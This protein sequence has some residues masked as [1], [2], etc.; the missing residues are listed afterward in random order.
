MYNSKNCLCFL[1]IGYT[2]T[3]AKGIVEGIIEEIDPYNF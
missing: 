2:T 1:V 3:V